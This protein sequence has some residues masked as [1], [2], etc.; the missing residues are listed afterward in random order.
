M[1]ALYAPW[2]GGYVRSKKPNGCIF[3]QN[4]LRDKDFV[5]WEGKSAYVMMNRYPYSCG[6]LMAIPVRHVGQIHELT[7]QER[8]EIFHLLDLSLAV[9]RETMTPDGFNV[10]INLGKIAGAG[11]DDHLHVHIVPR[12]NGDTNFMTVTGATRVIS[13]DLTQ[14]RN[15]LL[16]CF[17]RLAL[18]EG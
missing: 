1:D 6:H 11:V 18:Q 4:S 13:E 16:P 2:R 10:G 8:L 14:T 15:C 17:E 5:L 7:P 3:C 12:W 9:L